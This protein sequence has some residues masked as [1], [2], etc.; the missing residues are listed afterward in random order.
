MVLFLLH[1]D[2]LVVHHFVTIKEDVFLLD[3]KLLVVVHL[4]L[5]VYDVKYR[6]RFENKNNSFKY[7]IFE[8][9]LR[10]LQE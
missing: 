3:K 10:F 6:V 7:H 9:N 2:N 1:Q 4:V 5:L 8:K